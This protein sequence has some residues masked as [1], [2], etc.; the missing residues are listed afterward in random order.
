V[1]AATVVCG[2]IKTANATIYV[3]DRVLLPPK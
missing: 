1:N 3:I 2:N